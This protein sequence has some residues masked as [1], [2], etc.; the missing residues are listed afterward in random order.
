MTSTAPGRPPTRDQ[1]QRLQRAAGLLAQGKKAEALAEAR[2]LA[3]ELPAVGKVQHLLALTLKAEGQL[4]AARRAFEVALTLD[5]Q[6]P[7]LAANHANLL[8][9][10]GQTDAA[11][12][13]YRTALALDPGNAEAWINLSVSLLRTADIAGALEAA[14]RATVASPKWPAGWHALGAAQRAAGDIEGAAASLGTAVSLDPDNPPLRLAL[15]VAERIRG[16]PAASLGHYEVAERLG[17]RSPEFLD[18]R[19]SALLDVGDTAGAI[20]LARTL[21]ARHPD[22]AA[23]HIMLAE[24]L[25]EHGD[26]PEAAF[27]GLVRASAARPADRTLQLGAAQLFLAARKPQ[28]AI[29]VID[30][31]RRREDSASLAALAAEAHRQAGDIVGALERLADAPEVWRRDVVWRRAQVRVLLAARRPEHAA[32]A[33]EETLAWAGYDQE[34]LALIGT[35]WRM[36]GDLRER[37]L[38]DH[39]RLVQTVDLDV[40]RWIDGLRAHLLALHHARHAPLRQSL[41]NGSQTSGNLLGGDAPVI[42]QLREALEQAIRQALSRLPEDPSHPFLCRNTRGSRFVG[43]WSA[44]LLASGRHANHFHQQGWLSSAFYVQ[45][46]PSMGGDPKDNAGCLQF[47]QPDEDLGLTGLAPQHMVRPKVGRLALFPS[48]FWHGT[49]PF[50]DDT[51]RLTVA[52]DA[53]PA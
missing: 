16:R 28:A 15:G 13:R 25:W 20:A 12:T 39:E 40:A 7:Q 45:L 10:L 35:A 11:I 4:E 24:M 51:P 2:A 41:R 5:P 34:L 18:A 46:P 44:K 50:E 26:A 9:A 32:K 42:V 52:F 1:V 36:S 37:W 23:G 47:G 53:Q 3:I 30:E 19:A 33:A 31:L 29:I 49:V 43:S 14:R 48:Y 22:Y 17:M 8:V 6:D 38:C 27:E 21:C